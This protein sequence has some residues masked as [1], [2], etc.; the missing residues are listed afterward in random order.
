MAIQSA[1]TSAPVAKLTKATQLSILTQKISIV[2]QRSNS[3]Q[4]L[5]VKNKRATRQSFESQLAGLDKERSQYQ[6]KKWETSAGLYRLS[7]L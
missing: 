7:S 4:K 6:N 5:L 2:Q 1:S 3:Y